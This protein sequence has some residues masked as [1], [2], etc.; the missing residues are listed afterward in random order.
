MTNLKK[1]GKGFLGRFSKI[2]P[3]TTLINVTGERLFMPFYHIISNEKV[4]H[5]SHLYP[6]RD[7]IHFEKDLEY[8]LKYYE[9]IGVDK[10]LRITIGEETITRNSFFLSFDDGLKEM[11]EIVVP[12]LLKKGIPATFFINSGFVDNR[13][14][15]YRY[16]ASLLI[17]CVQTKK[18]PDQVLEQAKKKLGTV[19][20]GINE[21]RKALLNIT[22][23][24]K[25]I[26]DNIAELWELDFEAYLQT[27]QPYLTTAQC[28]E[29]KNKGF[30]F[31]AH[32]I[33]HPMYHTIP[34]EEQIRQT[35]ESLRWVS[36]NELCDKKLFAFPFT[37]Y[38]VSRAFFDVIF[39]V[40]NPVVDL[41]FG[42]AGLKGDY[43]GKHLQ[44]FPMEGTL[45]P[46]QKL[47]FGEY[48][49]YLLKMPLNKNRIERV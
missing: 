27:T 35:L 17:D 39:N 6:V 1:Y 40:G 19:A 31:G 13:D 36:E 2:I 23:Q 25:H 47:I 8:L 4:P 45:E 9:P 38:N 41:S 14:L 49:Y 42:G 15:F 5:I 28:I 11:Y 16:K 24:T 3:L 10:L 18:M 34:Y 46:A 37:D 33:D 26:L 12:I 48:L 32:S 44:R 20:K 21:I 29:L 43:A 30:S 7:I 22:Y